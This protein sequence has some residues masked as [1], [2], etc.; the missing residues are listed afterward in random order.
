MASAIDLELFPG[1]GILFSVDILPA[2]GVVDGAAAGVA[3]GAAS[4]IPSSR[5]GLG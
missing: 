2:A 3:A 4:A 5:E 1:A